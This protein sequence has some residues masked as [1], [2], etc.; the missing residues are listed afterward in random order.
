MGVLELA[1]VAVAWL[2]SPA[3][4]ARQ[5]EGPDVDPWVSD[6]RSR[7]ES[8][9]ALYQLAVE[10]YGPPSECEGAVTMEF[11]GVNFGS[12]IFGF[13]GGITYS[14][15]TMPPESSVRVLRAPGGFEEPE[16]VQQA[17][18]DYASGIGLAIDWSTPEVSEEAGEVIHRF[19]DPEPGLNA[20]GFLIFLD[21]TLVG[22]GSSLAL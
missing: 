11:D 6:F 17:L 5:C 21:D 16:Q 3:M 19:W 2:A 1:V 10:R 8:Y 7:V 13:R 18:R 15:E 22:I 4:L 9:D 12:L 20:S 14:V